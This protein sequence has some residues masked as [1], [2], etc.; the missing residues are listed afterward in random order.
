MLSSRTPRDFWHLQSVGHFQDCFERFTQLYSL[1]FHC[2]LHTYSTYKLFLALTAVVK[3][4]CLPCDIIP[5]NLYFLGTSVA[6]VP[7]D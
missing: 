7:G 1:T 2:F 3:L 5:R 6:A 4:F